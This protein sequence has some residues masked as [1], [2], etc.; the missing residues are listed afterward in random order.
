MEWPATLASERQ[1]CSA[2]TQCHSMGAPCRRGWDFCT[3]L[4]APECSRHTWRMLLILLQSVRCP[5]TFPRRNPLINKSPRL[6]SS[7]RPP[8]APPNYRVSPTQGEF[9]RFCTFGG[10]RNSSLV[11]IAGEDVLLLL[12][13]GQ[14]SCLSPPPHLLACKFRITESEK[15]QADKAGKRKPESR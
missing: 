10:A 14:P 3:S 6:V 12:R 2:A 9:G 4:V 13:G 8:Y 7:S 1:V 15:S 11:L 5:Q